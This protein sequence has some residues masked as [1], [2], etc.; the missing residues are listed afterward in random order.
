MNVMLNGQMKD[1]GQ[2]S[3]LSYSEVVRLAEEARGKT[4]PLRTREY[5]E[6]T[7]GM[8]LPGDG[9]LLPT[10]VTVTWKKS[11]GHGSLIEGQYITPEDGMILNATATDKA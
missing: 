10:A 5:F 1:I 2:K 11:S 6:T 4:F 9:K 3:S 8:R 7:S